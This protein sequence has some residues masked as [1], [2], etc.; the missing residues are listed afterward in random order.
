VGPFAKIPYSN[1]QMVQT[2]DYLMIMAEMVNDARIIRI[3]SEHQPMQ[4]RKWMGDSV[5]HWEGDTLVVS[6]RNIHPQQ[7]FRG[8]T[9]ALA[10]ARGSR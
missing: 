7:S 6:T 1:Y 3:D 10:G 5:A 9:G 2:S 4:L 8:S